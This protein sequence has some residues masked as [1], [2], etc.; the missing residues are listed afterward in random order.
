MQKA[1]CIEEWLGACKDFSAR[2]KKKENGPCT[3]DSSKREET[4]SEESFLTQL[5]QEYIDVSI[6]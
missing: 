3:L 6:S 5:I 2:G 1:P 4:K